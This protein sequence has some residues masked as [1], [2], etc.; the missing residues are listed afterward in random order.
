LPPTR[1][2]STSL[3]VTSCWTLATLSADLLGSPSLSKPSQTRLF[4]EWQLGGIDTSFSMASSRR[5]LCSGKEFS[6][7][8][9]VIGHA[10]SLLTPEYFDVADCLTKR[11]QEQEAACMIDEPVN[12]YHES[13][14]P[15]PLPFW[16]NPSPMHSHR[17]PTSMDYKK[18]SSKLRV[19]NGTPGIKVFHLERRDEA[20][21]A[22]IQVDVDIDALPHSEPAWIG[23]RNAQDDHTFEDGMGGHIYSEKEI[24]ELTG[25]DGMWY[26]NWLGVLTIP[27]TDSLANLMEAKANRLSHS[28][29]ELH[30][31][32]AKEPYPSVSRGPSYGRGQTEP[33]ELQNNKANTQVTDELLADKSFQHLIRFANVIFR[34]FAPILITALRRFNPDLSGHLILWDLKLVIRFPPGST[35]LIP[36]AII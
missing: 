35:I 25:V 2:P 9:M 10:A 13:N 33:S 15:D 16:I 17:P 26:I 34:I 11:I 27:I 6:A 31:R 32:R 8:D 23:K 28:E 3:L 21:S 29:E 36:S 4:T 30:H 22:A 5:T 7:F 19:K 14:D 1:H 12:D 24:R 20:L 18:K